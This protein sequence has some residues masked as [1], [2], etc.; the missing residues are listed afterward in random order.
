MNGKPVFYGHDARDI[1]L[2]FYQQHVTITLERPKHSTRKGQS[3]VASSGSLESTLSLAIVD[4]GNAERP[5]VTWQDDDGAKLETKMTEIAIE[6]VLAAESQYRESAIRQYQ[7][8]IERKAKFEQEERQRQ[9]QAER[10]ER[11]RQKR[12]EQGRIDRLLQDASAFYQAGQIRRYVEAIGSALR[13]DACPIPEFEHWK[14][15]A[16]AQADRI[17]PVQNKSFLRTM[18]V[19][20][21]GN[22]QDG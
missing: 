16:L 1:R 9:I 12:I 10:A 2:F 11:E 8:R 17:D 6:A 18:H 5:L 15:W 22:P 19:A 3:T 13:T 20:N 7:W 21:E 4:G 14:E